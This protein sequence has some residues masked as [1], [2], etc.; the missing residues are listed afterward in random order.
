M[1]S[2]SARVELDTRIGNVRCL[3]EIAGRGLGSKIRDLDVD[4]SLAGRGGG[5]WELLEG[6]A[7]SV[8]TQRMTIVRKAMW[9]G[10]RRAIVESMAGC[11]G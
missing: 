8:D 2:S 1:D 4:G 5:E 10:W 6:V 3:W 9:E 11:R 7:V